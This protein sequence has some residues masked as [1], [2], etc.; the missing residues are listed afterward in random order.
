MT[1]S[2]ATWTFLCD[3]ALIRFNN[4]TAALLTAHFTAVLL[5]A[6]ETKIPQCFAKAGK[7]E[8]NHLLNG[9]GPL[10]PA[11]AMLWWQRGRSCWC[12]ATFWWWLI[13]CIPSSE[14][15]TVMIKMS[16]LQ[17]I[18]ECFKLLVWSHFLTVLFFCLGLN[19]LFHTHQLLQY[20]GGDIRCALL[21]NHSIH[22]SVTEK[23]K[24]FQG[25]W[26]TIHSG[27]TQTLWPLPPWRALQW[28]WTSRRRWELDTLET[29][30]ECT[31]DDSTL[32]GGC[33]GPMISDSFPV[34]CSQV[35]LACVCQPECVICQNIQHDLRRGVKCN[36]C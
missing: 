11:V 32:L 15:V 29:R 18:K 24:L 7:M 1:S 25:L 26:G 9:F 16:H 17:L 2:N 35:S 8:P 20:E 4:L 21:P 28:C 30:A 23:G 10:Q 12:D 31:E 5:C 27:C 13:F 34:Q 22:A 3:V 19:M 33:K 36:S 14:Y 6:A